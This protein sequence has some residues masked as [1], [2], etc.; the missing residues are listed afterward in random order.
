LRRAKKEIMRLTASLEGVYKGIKKLSRMEG[1]WVKHV[2]RVNKA[3]DL[4]FFSNTAA[5][6]LSTMFSYLLN[7]II[8]GLAL[9]SA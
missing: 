3:D 7:S 2:L 5:K 6:K 1:N 8:V 9:A 4:I